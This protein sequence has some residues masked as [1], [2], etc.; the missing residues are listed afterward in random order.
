[1]SE[2]IEL[3][4]RLIDAFTALDLDEAQRLCEPDVRL[5]TLFDSPGVEPFCGHEGLRQWFTRL[6][7]LW[8]SLETSE[9]DFEERGDWVL[10]WGRARLR[11][12]D[13]P[14]EVES[15]FAAAIEIAGATV[16]SAGIYAG[17]DEAAAAIDAAPAG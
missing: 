6:D 11:G 4:R 15:E 5:A 10:A 8:S 12:R 16:V 9:V 13:S 7:H 2:N 17:R 3:A 14:G 1:M